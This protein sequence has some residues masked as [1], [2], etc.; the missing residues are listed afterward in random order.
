MIGLDDEKWVEVVCAVVTLKEGSQVSA[1]E[2]IAYARQHLAPF[3]VPK[4]VH[5]KD[6]L[7][8][9]ASGKLLKRELRK[10]FKG[11]ENA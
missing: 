9:N 6:D 5:F 3:K 4:A 1:E 10:E 11:L 8:R 7:P 2:L